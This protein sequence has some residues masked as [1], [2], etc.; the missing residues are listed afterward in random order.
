MPIDPIVDSAFP[1][2]V[3]Q[4]YN[5]RLTN[6]QS[7]VDT[8][9]ASIKYQI[10]DTIQN[11]LPSNFQYDAGEWI[12]DLDIQSQS[13]IMDQVIKYFR[14]RGIRVYLLNTVL[15]NNNVM[16]GVTQIDNSTNFLLVTVE[17]FIRDQQE[18]MKAYLD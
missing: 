13:R 3:Y 16:F 7:W 1:M 10:Y 14:A 17:W 15:F 9:V 8:L 2:D 5:D 18:F 6:D 11:Y 12:G 4:M